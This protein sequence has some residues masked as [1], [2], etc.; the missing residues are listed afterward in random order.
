[1]EYY[2]QLPGPN[3]NQQQQQ[4]PGQPIGLDPSQSKKLIDANARNI[5]AIA[6]IHEANAR[7]AEASA[8]MA[9]AQILLNG[10][11]EL[12]MALHFPAISEEQNAVTEKTNLKPLFKEELVDQLQLHYMQAY[13]RYEDFTKETLELYKTPKKDDNVPQ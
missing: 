7:S 2:I 10:M 3:Q 12:R 1:M 4:G 6:R 5:N 11:A 8:R 9:E 13:K